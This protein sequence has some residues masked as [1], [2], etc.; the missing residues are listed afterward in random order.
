M[1]PR[2]RFLTRARVPLAAMLSRVL[3]ALQVV[4]HSS[5]GRSA[6][7]PWSNVSSPAPNI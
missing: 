5:V 6:A 3:Q 7:V 1:P 4:L 2:R